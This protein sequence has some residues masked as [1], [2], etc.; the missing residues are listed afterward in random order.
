[1]TDPW[2][3]YVSGPLIGLIVPLLLLVG[4]RQ[5]GVSTNLRHLYA[6][7]G[8]SRNPFFNYDWKRE[9][10][11]NLVFAL[12]LVLGGFVAVRFLSAGSIT[13]TLGEATRADLARLGITE[14]S[15]FVPPQLVSWPALATWPGFVTMVVGGFLVGF[16]AR[17]AGGCTSGHAI[18]G[19][20]NFQW[21]SLLAV[22][23]FFAGGL[24]MT[25][26][27]LPLLF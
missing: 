12:G 13:P 26:V 6:A 27:L 1:M 14:I 19:L 4:G 16:G 11:W 18:S 25:H 2:P 22:V 21:P 17:W 8:L 15:G 20:A 7:C 9:G 10:A 23:G 24:L 3:W 5:F